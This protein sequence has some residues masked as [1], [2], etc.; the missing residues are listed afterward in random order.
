MSSD[1]R[2]IL[3]EAAGELFYGHGV[4]RASMDEIARRAGLTKRTLYKHFRS[5]DD[6]IAAYLE[7]LDEPVRRRYEGWLHAVPGPLESRLRH[8]FGALAIH[9]R[10]PRWKG[11]GFARAAHELAGFPGHPGMV[12]ARRH[13]A[14]FERWFAEELRAEGIGPEDTVARRL[15]ILLDGAITLTLVHHD[16]AY[17]KE[18]GNAAA[19]LVASGRQRT[20][21]VRAFGA[22]PNIAAGAE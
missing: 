10:N 16:P 15:M 21:D 6:L 22:I 1:T 5:K 13:R 11:C 3:L 14:A 8:M 17:M 19:D 9:A 12:A 7:A 18:A 4:A 20:R 2:A